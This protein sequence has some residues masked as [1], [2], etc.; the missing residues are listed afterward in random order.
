MPRITCLLLALVA[1]PLAAL[2]NPQAPSIY[3]AAFRT[4]PATRL[5]AQCPSGG[6]RASDFPGL[7]LLSEALKPFDGLVP[8]PELKE[9]IE[10]EFRRFR[11]YRL[12]DSRATADYVFFVQGTVV[13][14][15]RVDTD[16]LFVSQLVDETPNTVIDLT[17]FVSPAVWPE[18]VT[19]DYAGLLRNAR[20]KA[21]A[22]GINVGPPSPRALVQR[23]HRNFL[24]RAVREL[25]LVVGEGEREHERP[26]DQEGGLCVVPQPPL[27]GDLDVSRL[28]AVS[29]SDSPRL[30]RATA[31]AATAAVPP[32]S[33]RGSW[34][35]SS[36]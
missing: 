11:S 5:L 9:K 12:A 10:A 33:R 3:V 13:T 32:R 19:S 14:L 25:A 4:T 15:L 17:A 27:A 21:K 7:V 1:L 2:Q 31:P 8:D 28:I 34:Q 6:P 24:G 30:P 16:G 18:R 35:C 26:P 23:F 22:T 36:L 20:W 29:P